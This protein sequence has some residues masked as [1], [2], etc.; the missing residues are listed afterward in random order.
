MFFYNC[1]N[2]RKWKRSVGGG[3][4]E[5]FNTSA[6]LL[7]YLVSYL[8]G[9]NWIEI[10]RNNLNC[11]EYRKFLMASHWKLILVK[12]C[13]AFEEDDYVKKKVLS[14]NYTKSFDLEV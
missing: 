3:R 10:F 1:R 13:S 5:V 6:L 12:F 7:M 8:R 4:S 14:I 11:V 2:K 9:K